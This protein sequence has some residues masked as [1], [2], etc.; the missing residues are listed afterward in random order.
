LSFSFSR[1]VKP[2]NNL[3]SLSQNCLFYF[4]QHHEHMPHLRVQ[5]PILKL[6][7]NL[8]LLDPLDSIFRTRTLLCSMNQHFVGHI[9]SACCNRGLPHQVDS[10]SDR[11]MLECKELSSE[12]VPLLVFGYTHLSCFLH[13]EH[14]AKPPRASET[15][16]LSS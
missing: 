2:F 14:C 16:W 15:H 6:L 13:L 12:L 7:K 5:G 11:K 3:Q 4:Q 8:K 1:S 10:V 9:S